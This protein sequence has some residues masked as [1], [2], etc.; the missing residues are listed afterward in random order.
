[1][2]IQLLQAEVIDPK[3]HI[4]CFHVML[5]GCGPCA[6]TMNEWMLLWWKVPEI[7]RKVCLLSGIIK[8][9]MKVSSII[10]FLLLLPGCC[11]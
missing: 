4:F 7:N 11:S 3:N 2:I 1:M 9:K 5:P 10:Q 6:C 8:R